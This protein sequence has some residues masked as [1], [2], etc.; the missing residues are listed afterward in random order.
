MPILNI[1]SEQVVPPYLHTLLRV[2]KKA[3]MTSSRKTVIHLMTSLL[4]HRWLS[5]LF[6][7]HVKQM[8]EIGKKR[9]QA[10]SL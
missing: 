3:V 4:N 9:K 10:H 2:V 1:E 5:V 7:N 8:E 6:L